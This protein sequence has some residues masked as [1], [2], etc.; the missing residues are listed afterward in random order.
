MASFSFEWRYYRSEIRSTRPLCVYSSDDCRYLPKPTRS[1]DCRALFLGIRLAIYEWFVWI[2][3]V[4]NSLFYW[5]FTDVAQF[6]GLFEFSS[7]G[8][9]LVGLAE[10]YGNENNIES[11]RR[12][13]R[14]DTG[15]KKMGG[16][17][18][19]KVTEG[20]DDI[21]SSHHQHHP[22][23]SGKQRYFLPTHICFP[24]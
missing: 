11:R 3:L 19:K 4:R 23:V 5:Q 10:L 9:L 21:I 13:S 18:E 17:M 7:I 15:V 12:D 14:G 1:V 8:E 22:I 16:S 24:P 2:Y 6:P 20:D